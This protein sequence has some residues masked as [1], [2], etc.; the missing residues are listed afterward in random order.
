MFFIGFLGFTIGIFTHWLL[1]ED[2]IDVVD[3]DKIRH[4]LTENLK[5]L[6]KL[7]L[8]AKSDS[9][10]RYVKKNIYRTRKSIKK[11]SLS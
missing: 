7:E 6:Q 4:N 2:A 10:R 1:H 5:L 3:K 11:L 9:Y 8:N